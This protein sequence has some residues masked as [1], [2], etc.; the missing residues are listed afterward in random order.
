MEVPFKVV[1]RG[2]APEGADGG[3]RGMGP[4]TGRARALQRG[5]PN[6]LPGGEG[7]ASRRL[8]LGSAGARRATTAARDARGGR[9]R[10][11][12]DAGVHGSNE[13]TSSGP[14]TRSRLDDL[15]TLIGSSSLLL[16][17][18][19]ERWHRLVTSC[20]ISRLRLG[21]TMRGVV[22]RG[23]VAGTVTVV[24]LAVAN[25]AMA[26]ADRAPERAVSSV[27]GLRSL[28]LPDSGTTDGYGAEGGEHVPE[29]S[30]EMVGM[31]R[32]HHRDARTEDATG[33]TSRHESHHRGAE[34]DRQPMMRADRPDRMETMHGP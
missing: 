16:L 32:A 25:P 34:A 13:T 20:W 19:K 30:A 29:R 27:L 24:G 8:A 1:V 15:T 12:R 3:C 2:R 18:L 11:R 33:M 17:C 9:G 28:L 6:G 23:L 5:R 21:S 31:H 26:V 4:R 10:A 22:G 7:G 14:R